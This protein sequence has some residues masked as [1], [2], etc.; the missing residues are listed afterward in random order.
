M[1]PVL[2]IA[3]L[4]AILLLLIPGL[5]ASE[6]ALEVER[7]GGTSLLWVESAGKRHLLH[8]TDSELTIRE[9]GGDPP[10]KAFFATWEEAG[11]RW[12]AYSRDGGESW[13]PSRLL[14]RELRLVDGAVAP[15][16]S[17]P[18][19][20]VEFMQ[21][22][23]D[24]LRIVQFKTTSLPEWREAL[25]DAGAEI[26]SYFPHNAHI[27]R[28]DPESLAAIASFEFVERVEPY[29]PWYRLEPS[30]ATVGTFGARTGAR[31]DLRVGSG[32]QRESDRSG[33]GARRRGGESWPSGHVL[34]LWAT[35][36]SCA[37]SPPTTT[38]S[39]STAGANRNMTWTWSARIPAPTGCRT[40][41]A[42]A[43][44]GCAAR[45][46]TSGSRTTTPT[47][48]ASCCM[49]P[50]DSTAM[51]PPPTASSS[52]TATGMATAGAR[53]SGICPA[54][55]PRGYSPT[56]ASSPIVSCTPRN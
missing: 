28:V 45:S 15:G 19:P 38:C 13:S 40:A 14:R 35:R 12:S 17:I 43:A 3:F 6:P 36:I 48:T 37:R 20:P 32:G 24:R 9:A 50:T 52:V 42:T 16:S 56:T 51:A 18:Q 47:S 30:L 41:S 11:A 54:M 21:R 34:E 7:S 1:R 25:T 33:G 10:D 5:L 22:G 23:D 31:H 39:G 27:V 26:L 2:F 4:S 44:R 29:H 55:R 46:W 53:R 49:A 8:E